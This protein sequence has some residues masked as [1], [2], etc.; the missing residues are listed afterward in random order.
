MLQWVRKNKDRPFFLYY[1][2]VLPH[3][4]LQAPEEAVAQYRGKWPETPY[5]GKSYLPNPTPRA[6]YAA[7]ISF[8]DYQVGRLLKLLDKLNL[9]GNTVVFFTSDNG[10]TMLIKQVDYEFFHSVGPLRGLKGSLH[11][12][13][14]REPLIVRWPGKIAP[15]SI[16]H[17]P[18]VQ[19][20]VMATLAELT[21]VQPPAGT[22]S[23]SFLP[24]LLGEPAKQQKHKYL[25]WDFT[26]YGGQVAVRLGKWK[27]I[28][29]NLKKNP[30]APL[31][32]YDL[33]T[34]IG[35]QHNVARQYPKIAAE[36]A[37]IMVEGRTMPAAESFRFWKYSK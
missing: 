16:T 9:A 31:E 32:L 8:M 17:L 2:T 26:G 15:A 10:T 18:A 21:G 6:T 37:K 33:E 4:P 1:P 3:L 34:D 35:E 30:D 13:G 24:A 19:Y 23:V 22:D 12:G 5:N 28:K 14:I 29:T 36:M 25:F 7:M 11:E 27:A 20:D